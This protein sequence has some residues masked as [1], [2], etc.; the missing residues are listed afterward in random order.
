MSGP[1]CLLSPVGDAFRIIHQER[2]ELWAE[3]YHTDDFHP[4]AIGTY[5]SACVLYA[6]VSG[7]ALNTGSHDPFDREICLK[8]LVSRA[9][10]E[11]ERTYL[12]GI[13][14]RVTASRDGCRGWLQ[15]IKKGAGV[16][17]PTKWKQWFVTWLQVYF[18]A[19]AIGRVLGKS[20]RYNSLS[21][22][23]K[24]GCSTMLSTL[25]I[26]YFSMPKV[27]ALARETGF[28]P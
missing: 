22:L 2:R 20:A 19:Y 11:E 25:I 15:T 8:S 7:K 16:K 18:W 1:G 28:F 23:T 24:M 4:S 12:Q 9:P 21:I 6:T 10:N 14:N 17:A 13:A 26:S 3:L 5:L 27:L